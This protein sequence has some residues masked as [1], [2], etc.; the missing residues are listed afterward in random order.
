MKP[1]TFDRVR[2]FL[3]LNTKRRPEKIHPESRLCEDLGIAGQDGFELIEDF[4]S[5]FALPPCPVPFGWY[6][7]AE[8]WR[9]SWLLG[10]RR[11]EHLTLTVNDLVASV[12]AGV[13]LGP[14]AGAAE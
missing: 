1:S 8:G 12:D 7:G 3:A 9:L 10:F 4:F 11:H 6:F 14:D 2:E 13:W 5:E